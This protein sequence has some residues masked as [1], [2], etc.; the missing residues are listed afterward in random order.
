MNALQSLGIFLKLNYLAYGIGRVGLMRI[1]L[2]ALWPMVLFPLFIYSASSARGLDCN[3]LVADPFLGIP[4][5][6]NVKFPWLGS[7]S[8]ALSKGFIIIEYLSSMSPLSKSW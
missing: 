8:W 6:L 4:G 1:V 5:N 7:L 2:A 3:L